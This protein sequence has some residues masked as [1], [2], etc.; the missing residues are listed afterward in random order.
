M[1][2]LEADG[3]PKETWTR[4]AGRTAV[5]LWEGPWDEAFAPPSTYVCADGV[6]LVLN[7]IRTDGVNNTGVDEEGNNVYQYKEVEAN[8][9]NPPSQGG[10]KKAKEE[11]AASFGLNPLEW[12]VEVQ[13]NVQHLTL[14]QRWLRWTSDDEFVGKDG[15]KIYATAEI[16]ATKRAGSLP[17]LSTIVP[18]L[19]KINSDAMFS[20]SAEGEMAIGTVLFLGHSTSENRD[21]Q[22]ELWLGGHAYTL[23]HQ[24]INAGHWYTCITAGTSAASGGPTTID[25]NITDGTV[26]WR[27]DDEGAWHPTVS[28][29]FAVSPNTW[30]MAWREKTGAWEAYYVDNGN[31]GEDPYESAALMG[32][33][34]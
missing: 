12:S 11:A 34:A 32:L 8:Y 2:F 19:G 29:R 20:G 21:E 27:Y 28:L 18:L 30:N 10:A 25:D 33:L 1:S 26:H 4:D 15:V 9:D 14:P 3:Y 23:R 22:G 13:S 5:D 31:G 7:S 16:V 6:T 17:R 24:V